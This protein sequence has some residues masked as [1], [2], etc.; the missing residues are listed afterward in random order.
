VFKECQKG[1]IRVLGGM[2]AFD[3]LQGKRV[4]VSVLQNCKKGV[5]RCSK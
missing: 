3:K 5:T 1:V 4:L 2:R